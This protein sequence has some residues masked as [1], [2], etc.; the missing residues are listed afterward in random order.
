MQVPSLKCPLALLYRKLWRRG[1]EASSLRPAG[2]GEGL[3]RTRLCFVEISHHGSLVC[4][5]VVPR[6]PLG[7]WLRVL[8]TEFSV[9]RVLVEETHKRVAQFGFNGGEGDSV[10]P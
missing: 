10:T 2:H 9:P 8:R 1:S 6:R 3:P 4:P 7:R 5:H